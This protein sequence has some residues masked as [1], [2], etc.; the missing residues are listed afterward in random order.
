MRTN[1][2]LAAVGAAAAF[3]LLTACGT[4]DDPSAAPEASASD[5]MTSEAT[6]TIVDVASAS[7][8]FTT[9]VAAIQAAD[10]VDTLSGDGPFTVFAPTD[11]AFAALPPGVLDALLLPE[12]KDTL[13]KILTYHVVEGQ[14]TSDQISDGDVATVEGQTVTLSTADGVTVNGAMV[15]TADI[16]TSNGVIHVIDAVLVPSDV[17]VA[18]LTS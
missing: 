15:T 14:V 1:R 17:D 18:A 12:N 4:T 11:E 6:G 10:L 8:D 2:A 7:G 5:T 16:E 9:L 3:L 13:A